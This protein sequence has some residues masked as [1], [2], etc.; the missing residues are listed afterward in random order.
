MKEAGGRQL[1]LAVAIP[2]AVVK[3][4]DVDALHEARGGVALFGF[5]SENEKYSTLRNPTVAVA[6]LIQG[7]RD[8]VGGR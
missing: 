3:A 2:I 1:V 6:E 8:E 4:V 7:S 5:P